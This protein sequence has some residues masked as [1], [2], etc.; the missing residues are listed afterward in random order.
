MDPLKSPSEPAAPSAPA[1]ATAL[2]AE[3]LAKVEDALRDRFNRLSGEEKIREYF[4]DSNTGLPN[5]RGFE[6]LHRAPSEDKPLFAHF[7]AEGTK[8][9]NEF[10]HD[11]GQLLYRMVA[12]AL[13]AGDPDVTKVRGDFATRVRSSEEAQRIADL[14][15]ALLP[16]EFKGFTITVATGPTLEEA[17]ARHAAWK[18]SMEDTGH[19]AKRGER[20]LGVSKDWTPET[21]PFP[22]EAVTQS[23]HLPLVKAYWRLDRETA[24]SA[25]R[26]PM[27]GL[28]SHTGM[29]A[30]ARVGD[31]YLSIDVDGLKATDAYSSGLG[32]EVIRKTGAF[33]RL[34]GGAELQ[35]AHPHGDEFAAA[36]PDPTVL[37]TYAAQLETFLKGATV[38]YTNVHLGETFVQR[39]VGISYGIGDTYEEAERNLEHHKQQRTLAG[40]RDRKGEFAIAR[41]RLERRAVTPDDLARERARRGGA[42]QHERL[43]DRGLASRDDR[44]GERSPPGRGGQS[45]PGG[46]EARSAAGGDHAPHARGAAPT[47]AEPARTVEAPREQGRGALSP[48]DPPRALLALGIKPDTLSAPAFAGRWSTDADGRVAFPS[49]GWKRDARGGKRRVQTGAELVGADGARVG[50]GDRCGIWESAGRGRPTI[51]R[52]VVTEQAVDALSYHQLRGDPGTHYVSIGGRLTP[53]KQSEIRDL[54]ELQKRIGSGLTVVAAFG[55][56]REAPQLHEDLQVCVPPGVRVDREPPARGRGWSDL[57]QATER[58]HIR[59]QGLKAPPVRQQGPSLGI[60]R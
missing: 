4:Y 37:A 40:E 52:I 32:D 45:I 21:T 11:Q 49:E 47:R 17:G 1:G 35:A 44:G 25:Y 36:H 27:T 23:P 5:E 41:A 13:H 29:G 3:S 10:G 19:R 7:S 26:D 58:D 30:A 39:G 2:G 42:H 28:L 55:H 31:K 50:E 59:A 14:A 6:A 51:T 8:F 43:R 15:N 48:A 12:R 34:L 16:D 20:P 56:S 18:Q 54:I 22:T 24:L 53:E 60:T 33:M 57:V 9:V 38:S 46:V